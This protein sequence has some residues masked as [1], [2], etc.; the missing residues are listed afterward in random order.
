VVRSA[1][2]GKMIP[3]DR[4]NCDKRCNSTRPIVG[5]QVTTCVRLPARDRT[6]KVTAAIKQQATR[7]A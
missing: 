5:I 6:A 1:H 2:E 7:R 3:R 4:D